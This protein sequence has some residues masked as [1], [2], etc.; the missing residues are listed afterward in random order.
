SGVPNLASRLKD[1][2][3]L[4]AERLNPFE[5]CSL[6]R[7]INTDRLKHDSALLVKACGLALRSIIDRTQ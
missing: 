2:L 1:D 5:H 4:Q 3:D 6:N 7:N